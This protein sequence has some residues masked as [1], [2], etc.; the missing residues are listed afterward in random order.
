[1]GDATAFMLARA[2][3]TGAL[4][5]ERAGRLL[6]PLLLGMLV[7]VPPQTRFEVR[8]KHG[9]EG[10]FASFMRVYLSGA[11]AFCGPGG[12]LAMPTWNHRGS[13]PAF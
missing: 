1:M 6:E 13:C 5:R 9:Y 7:V 2:G 11:G 12:R 3:A 10:S 4:L 8:Q